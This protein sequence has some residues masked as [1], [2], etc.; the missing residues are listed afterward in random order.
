MLTF[1][2][3]VPIPYLRA[4]PPQV[5]IMLS[6]LLAMLMLPGHT[7]GPFLPPGADIDRVASAMAAEALLGLAISISLA[8]ML[9]VVVEVFVVASRLVGLNAGFG[10]ASTIDPNTQ[11]DSG[12]LDILG[13]LLASLVIVTAG[14]DR[15]I[16]LLLSRALE[17]PHWPDMTIG[18]RAIG[19]VMGQAWTAGARLAL[20]IVVLLIVI[21]LLLALGSKFQA[22]LQMI[23][24]SFPL[25][26]LG[27]MWMLAFGLSLWPEVM[28]RVMNAA[29]AFL[30][31]M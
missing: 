22:Q 10:Y 20:P 16:L 6:L 7:R 3:L 14:M 9:G 24:L 8:V 29:L 26:I 12:V 30:A 15:H 4:A 19:D 11:A 18:V 1:V 2:F 5:K 23:T 17:T 27:G 28:L 21:D 13:G 25:K 31:R